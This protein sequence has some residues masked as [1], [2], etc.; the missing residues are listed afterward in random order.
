MQ[1]YKDRLATTEAATGRQQLEGSN[2]RQLF[3]IRRLRILRS[4]AKAPN[5]RLSS[6][7]PLGNYLLRLARSVRASGRASG[8]MQNQSL[9]SRRARIILIRM[10]SNLNTSSCLNW[11]IAFIQQQSKKILIIV[12]VIC[13][14]SRIT[15]H[16]H[17]PADDRP[18]SAVEKE[19]RKNRNKIKRYA[20]SAM[21][22]TSAIKHCCLNL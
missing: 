13:N 19:A 21:A 12:I 2:R 22:V 8:A 18:E 14:E 9:S 15:S 5:G 11:A 16:K 10:I 3:W 7:N 17:Q 1:P 20:S 6:A 4:F